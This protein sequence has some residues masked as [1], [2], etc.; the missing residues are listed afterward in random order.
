[1]AS[2][3]PRINTP[4]YYGDWVPE[5]VFK[6]MLSFEGELRSD[7]FNHIKLAKSKGKGKEHGDGNEPDGWPSVQLMIWVPEDS[8][9][10]D[11]VSCASRSV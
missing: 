8:F 7:I 11:M 6:V 9:H 3:P 5:E 10:S 1:L 2:P 4:G